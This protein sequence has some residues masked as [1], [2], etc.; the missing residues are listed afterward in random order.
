M[1]TLSLELGP[2]TA[3]APISWA[4]PFNVDE[5]DK[6]RLDGDRRYPFGRPRADNANYLWIQTESVD[7]SNE[8]A[9]QGSTT[10]APE[11]LQ[12]RRSVDTELPVGAWVGR[13]LADP[14][15]QLGRVQLAKLAEHPWPRTSGRLDDFAGAETSSVA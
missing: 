3:A 1:P 14:F 10:V 5:V 2:P 12:S 9:G 13:F 4:R 11:R 7:S 8:I 6:S 15:D